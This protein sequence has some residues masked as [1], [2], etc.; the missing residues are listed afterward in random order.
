MRARAVM[1]RSRPARAAAA[2][3]AARRGRRPARRDRAARTRRAPWGRVGRRRAGRGDGGRHRRHDRNRRT[4]G[5]LSPI[6]PPPCDAIG[7]EP[8]IPTA[9]TTVLATKTV[10][11]G[12]PERRDARYP[13]DSDRDQRV[14]GRPGGAP[15]GRRR[16]DRLRV[17]RAVAQVGR[18]PVA[19]HG[20]DAVR[21]T[22]R[23]TSNG[24]PA[25]A[26]ATTPATRR[27]RPINVTDPMGSGVVGA[28]TIDGRGGDVLTGDT[29]NWWAF[30]DMYNGDLAA[31]RLIQVNFGT[32]FVLYKV[33]L[34]NAA[35]FHVVIDDGRLHGVGHY[36]QHA[37]GFAQH[38]RRRSFA[39]EERC[40]CLHEDHDRRRQHRGQGRRS[41]PRRRAA[42]RAQPFRPRPRHV[43]RQ[44]DQRRRPQRQ[45]LRPV[46]RRHR[47]R[48][49]H[50]VR[51]QPRGPGAGRRLH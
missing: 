46:A 29:N 22:T 30:E 39:R 50:Q 36:H 48:A 43:D 16:Q 37:R 1:A 51:R 35:K 8:T 34:K 9:C 21:S 10:I 31:P 40:H 42:G 20:H 27:A 11:D 13:G 49:A 17:G 15:R 19:R 38:R 33:T 12:E 3:G 7:S 32:D 41:G 28:G 14:P 18:Q 2:S 23:A 4:A 5:T 25:S 45:R 47:Q 44:R 24:R 6:N 26:P